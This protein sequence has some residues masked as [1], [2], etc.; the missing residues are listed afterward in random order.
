MASSIVG[1]LLSTVVFKIETK[2]L[3]PKILDVL[4]LKDDVI[5]R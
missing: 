5:V 2:S 4:E 1:N 3:G